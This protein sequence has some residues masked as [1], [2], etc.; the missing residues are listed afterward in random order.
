MKIIVNLGVKVESSSPFLRPLSRL[1]I[2]SEPFSTTEGGGKGW[3]NGR[4][5]FF[6]F[7]S[8]IPM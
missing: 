1:K 5:C 3:E 7:P 6:L 2:T 4:G 8:N